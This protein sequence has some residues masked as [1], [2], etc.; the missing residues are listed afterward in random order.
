MAKLAIILLGLLPFAAQAHFPLLTCSLTA[1]QQ[2]FC[3]AGFSDGSLAGKV[4][5]N[6]FNYDDQAML[7]VTTASDGS[8]TITPPT[9]EYYIVFDPDHES[10]AEFD[11][12]Q[13][14]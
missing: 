2:L 7:T 14:N 8:V 1:K 10:P 11:Y 6:V 9:G 4:S 5:L 13:L 3:V 12:V